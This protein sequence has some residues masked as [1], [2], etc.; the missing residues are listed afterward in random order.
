MVIN[1]EM[2]IG[3]G[4]PQSWLFFRKS[5][6]TGKF[7]GNNSET[8]CSFE[9]HS[10]EMRSQEQNNIWPD[11]WVRLPIINMIELSLSDHTRPL[12]PK[13]LTIQ[14]LTCTLHNDCIYKRNANKSPLHIQ[15]YERV[16]PGISF[17]E[18]PHYYK[19]KL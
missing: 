6:K 18:D 12:A 10:N 17:V 14:L 7:K 16:Q 8:S 4:W 15:L 19:K 3:V 11:Y 1:K 9:S 13:N 5:V 2:R